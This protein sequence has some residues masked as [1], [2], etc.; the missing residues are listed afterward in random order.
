MQAHH[1]VGQH[2]LLHHIGQL[3]GGLWLDLVM[4]YRRRDSVF[5]IQATPGTTKAT[6]SVSCQF[7]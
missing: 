7:R 3:V 1:A 5:M 2:V 4:R 6:I